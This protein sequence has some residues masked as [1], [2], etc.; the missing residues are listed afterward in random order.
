H[1]GVE[2]SVNVG[3]R[4]EVFR[5]LEAREA[6]VAISGKPPED[7]GFEGIPFLDN[8]FVLITAPGDPRALRKRVPVEELGR[9]PWLMREPGSGTRRLCELYLDSHQLQPPVLTLGSN[10]AIKSA[11][12][13]ELGIALQSR[14]SVELELE[15][16]HLATITPRGGLPKR[17]WHIVRP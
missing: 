12:R 17:A 1:P 15:A 3:N 5:R 16:D 13:M 11:A 10:G 6:D 4:E 8:E 7:R 14:L 2:L 9:T